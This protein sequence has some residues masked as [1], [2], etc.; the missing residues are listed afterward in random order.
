MGIKMKVM[1]AAM[2]PLALI[3]VLTGW[4]QLMDTNSLLQS[5]FEEMNALR[6]SAAESHLGMIAG[7]GTR[8]SEADTRAGEQTLAVIESGA[9]RELQILKDGQTKLVDT[10]MSLGGPAIAGPLW[11]FSKDAVGAVADGLLAL[12]G[13]D[14]V[15]VLESGKPFIERG[16]IASANK[17]TRDIM[18]DGKAIGQLALYLN[19][20]E[21][22]ATLAAAQTRTEEARRTIEGRVAEVRSTIQSEQEQATQETRRAEDKARATT[23]EQRRTLETKTLLK[24]FGV[25]VAAVIGVAI[26]LNFALNTVLTPLR[27]MTSLMKDASEGKEV[28]IPYQDRTDAI[29]RQAD[30]LRTFVEA[31]QRSH[32]LEAEKAETERR[33]SIERAQQRQQMA[34]EFESRVSTVI[35]QVKERVKEM[36][37]SVGAMSGSA[38]SNRG[39]AAEARHTGSNVDASV[40]TVASAIEEMSA[41]ISEIDRATGDTQSLMEAADNMA[42]EGVG[43]VT[44]LVESADRIGAVV[45][46]ISD[47]AEQT[48]LLALNATIE[49]ARAGDAGKGFAVVASEVKSLA[50]QTAKAT[51]EIKSQV[52][53]IQGSTNLAAEN[54][55]RISETLVN[56][57]TAVGDIARSVS[58]QSTATGEISR[59]VSE[60]AR[61]AG[62][63][64]S[65]TESVEAEAIQAF[66]ASEV[67][68]R[69]LSGLEQDMAGL[70]HSIEDFLASLR[71]R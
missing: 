30:A 42:Q 5:S 39:M 68:D 54:I 27:I 32:Q 50:T 17:A 34:A 25:T 65:F 53:G 22:D 71:Q 37:V 59:S 29:G 6:R 44:G 51:E 38:Q 1:I 14:G 35:N 40:N 60:T 24:A 45:N 20:S 15:T 2:A 18:R 13:I 11:D 69:G 10:A 8:L 28:E 58:E 31:M 46:L 9:Q 56:A 19:T 49:A 63:L 21:I 47:I 36:V 12:P 62:E 26:A 3:L 67:V 23:E 57:N 41:S 4:F 61:G 66:E 43:S 64:N 55:R 70:D 52:Q 33:A 48:N 7:Q 16:D